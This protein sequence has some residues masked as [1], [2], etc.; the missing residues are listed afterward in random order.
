MNEKVQKILNNVRPDF[1]FNISKDY[2]ND[3]GLDSFDLINLVTELDLEFGVSI[4]GTKIVPE[5]FKSIE[6][7]LNLVSSLVKSNK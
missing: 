7:I 4:P 5:N 1:D 2:I 3:G 6:S